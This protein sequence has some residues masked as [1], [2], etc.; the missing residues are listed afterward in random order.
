VIV[1]RKST[2]KKPQSSEFDQFSQSGLSATGQTSLDVTKIQIDLKE[3]HPS[4]DIESVNLN[5]ANILASDEK[6]TRK[7]TS[8]YA[9]IV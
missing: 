4:K 7:F 3:F 6:R 9:Q 1:R 2:K 5:K 8:R